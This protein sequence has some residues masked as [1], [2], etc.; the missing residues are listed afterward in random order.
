ML[1]SRHFPV[2]S[3]MITGDPIAALAKVSVTN[4][5]ELKLVV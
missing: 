4:T 1:P 5:T 3:S 2:P